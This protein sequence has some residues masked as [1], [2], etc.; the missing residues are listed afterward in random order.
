MKAPENVGDIKMESSKLSPR[1]S[2]GEECLG[3]EGTLSLLE[4]WREILGERQVKDD[5]EISNNNI[6]VSV[7][8]QFEGDI[9]RCLNNGVEC[10]GSALS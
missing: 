8:P 9:S 6:T 7:G 2:T 3:H 5:A 4:R 1:S 10:I